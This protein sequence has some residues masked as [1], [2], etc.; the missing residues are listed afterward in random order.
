M[1]DI[2]NDPLARS[3]NWPAEPSPDLDKVVGPPAFSRFLR[4]VLI[5]FGGLALMTVMLVVVRE[6]KYS[7]RAAVDGY[8]SALEERDTKAAL[9]RLDTPQSASQLRRVCCT[10]RWCRAP[11]IPRRPTTRSPRSTPTAISRR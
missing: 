6:T 4:N 9:E 1:V 3:I 10:A 7:P 8:L 11:T 2:L 5:V